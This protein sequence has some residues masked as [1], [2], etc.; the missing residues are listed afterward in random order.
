M[1]VWRLSV[2][3]LAFLSPCMLRPARCALHAVPCM[4][5][6][7]QASV[8]L[9]CGLKAALNA[10]RRGNS[11]LLVLPPTTSA[12]VM[13][14]ILPACKYCTSMRHCCCDLASCAVQL[15]IQFSQTFE[16]TSGMLSPAA[17]PGLKMC[18]SM[19]MASFVYVLWVR[20]HAF[21]QSSKLQHMYC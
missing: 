4:L 9:L 18:T 16:G 11:L 7:A 13:C 14:S 15:S 1:C 8:Q 12:I 19:T 20:S 5:C 2:C 6:P 21:Q 10:F 17:G 3:F